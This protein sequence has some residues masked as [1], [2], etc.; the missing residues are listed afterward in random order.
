MIQKIKTEF[1][2]TNFLKK[3]LDQVIKEKCS[4]YSRSFIKKWILTG[5]VKVDGKIE[6]KPKK[7]F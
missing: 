6:K 7:K 2:I 4:K 1:Q 3:R 5:S